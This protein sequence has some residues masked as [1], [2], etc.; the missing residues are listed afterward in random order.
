MPDRAAGQENR[1]GRRP[2][3]HRRQQR[4]CARRG[5]WRRY[6]LC[7]VSHYTV[8]FS[9]RRLC[10]PLQ[11]AAARSR[12]RQGKIRHRARR[13]RTGFDWH[14]DR[15]VVER[16]ARLHRHLRARHLAD[17]G[18]YRPV[19]FRRSAGRDHE[20]AAR[21][22]I[23]RHADTDP[24]V[25]HHCLRLCFPWRYQAR[26]AVS[27]R[28]GRSLRI[29]RT[30]LRSRRPPADHHLRHARSRYRHEPSA[31]SPAEMGRRPAIRPRQGD[32]GGDA[33]RGTRFWALSRCRW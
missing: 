18:I 5:L 15:R 16:R 13:G 11:E 10:Q 14:R 2:H 30:G 26:D 20:R 4:G 17:D 1:Q 29:R 9:R 31:Q 8:I 32:D 7:M 19:V 22:S 6:G 21:R 28:P 23:D 3:L 24:A 25:R 33:G 27:G 12:N